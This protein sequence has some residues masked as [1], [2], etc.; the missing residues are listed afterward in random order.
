METDF[1][2]GKVQSVDT[3][4]VSIEVDKEEFLNNVQINQ[5]VQIRSTKTGEKII[6]LISKIIR[7]GI[8]DKIDENSEPDFIIENLIK[9]NLVGT[10]IEKIGSEKNIFKRTLNT[11][12]SINAD[13]FLLQGNDL[14]TFMNIIS[15]NS[16]N[17]L[18]IGKYTIAEESDANLDG[19]KFFQRHAVI[20]GGTGSGK[21]W[22]VANVLEK[23]TK[24]KSINSV[25]FDL[26]GEYKPLA[27][28]ENTTLLKIAGPSDKPTDENVMFLPYW[29]L[30][31]EEIESML[32]DRSD[33]NA[34]N[35]SRALFDLI[36]K[37]KKEKLEEE[38]QQD[39]LNNFTVES[40]IPYKI[41]DVLTSLQEL[42]TERDYSSSKAG[43]DGPLAKKLTRFIQRLKS[44]Q[45]DKRLNFIFNSEDELLQYDW[46]IS[47]I[48]NLLDFGNNKGLKIID[49]SE[50][51]SDILPL[52]TGL[53]GRLIFSIQQWMEIEKRHPIAIFCDEAHLYIPANLKGGI[54]EKGLQSF[55]RIAKEGRKYGV[56]LVVISQRPSDVNKT[57]LSQCGNF[58]AMRLTNP[59]DQNVIKK[60]FPD[61][62]GGFS[63]MLPILDVGEALIVGDAC[64]LPSRVIID[65]PVIQP[66]SATVN[67]WDEWS[68]NK[69]ESGIEQ[70]IESLRKQQ[71]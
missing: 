58:V 65:K 30:S 2:I 60:L 54:E 40:P 6:G 11:V 17:P 64:L 12:P 46:F 18:K 35:Q 47:L 63:D 7:K 42:D 21:S 53:I 36:I 51:P 27:K 43:R 37:Y 66:D 68:K 33:S 24:L 5:I 62:L 49:F 29:L 38:D 15:S 25:I 32:L 8:A 10:L 26:H 70:A 45:A 31:Y 67:F 52:I 39:V 34:P 71:K 13:C 20:V 22:T 3:G 61:N 4:N 28:L 48:K 69:T 59:D 41:S 14:S 56:S 1:L 19:N 55:E 57:I 23:A 16:E 9:V 50:V 44:K